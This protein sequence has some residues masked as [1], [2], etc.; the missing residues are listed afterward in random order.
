VVTV[1]ETLGAAFRIERDGGGLAIGYTKTLLVL[2]QAADQPRSGRHAFGILT[3]GPP[4]VASVRRVIGL[5]LGITRHEVGLTLGFS[6]EASLAE[7]DRGTSTAR[8]LVLTPDDP[9]KVRLR[10]C[11][12]P[13][14]E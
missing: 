1:T 14:C 5:D 9:A 13:S 2:P 11:Q 10:M 7:I 3:S 12:A 4:A 8:L 6:E